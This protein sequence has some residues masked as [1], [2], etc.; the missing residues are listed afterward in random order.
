M[1]YTLS[2][3]ILILYLVYN[4]VNSPVYKMMFCAPTCSYARYDASHF[5]NILAY[6]ANR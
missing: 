6:C 4:Y 1:G 2:K 3:R 5:R